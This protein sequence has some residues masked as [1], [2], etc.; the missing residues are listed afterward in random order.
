FTVL[1]EENLSISNKYDIPSKFIYAVNQH[2]MRHLVGL[3]E[4]NKNVYR[5]QV[6]MGDN[7]RE[8]LQGADNIGV[9]LDYPDKRVYY[10]NSIPN[11]GVIGT[12]ATYT[13]VAVGV[14]AALYVLLYDAL[15]PGAY[16]VEDL[17]DTHYKYFMFDNLRVQEF[18]FK[19]EKK[20]LRLVQYLPAIVLR[21]KDRFDHF[22][23]L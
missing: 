23:I 3:Y 8:F 2:T 5:K 7:T 6:E 18:V 10:F 17:Y 14:F 16:F 11:L 20:G 9:Y 15:S 12:N 4:K 22:Y 13:Q 1:H 19:K 21:R